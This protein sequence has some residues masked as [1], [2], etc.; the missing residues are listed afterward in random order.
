MFYREL[1]EQKLEMKCLEILSLLNQLI[2]PVVYSSNTL[3]W[4]VIKN[5]TLEVQVFYL[6]M[7]GDY[8]RYLC[9]FS[10]NEE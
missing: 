2:I 6:K 9:E 10:S 7:R 3:E 4:M 8:Y 1:I 5:T